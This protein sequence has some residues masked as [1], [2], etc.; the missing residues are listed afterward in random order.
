IAGITRESV[1]KQLG[2]WQK[3]GWIATR[4][5]YITVTQAGALGELA[6]LESDTPPPPDACP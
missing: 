3:A 5:G 6:Q 1:N 4:N 2:L